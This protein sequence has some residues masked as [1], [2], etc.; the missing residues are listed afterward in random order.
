MSQNFRDIFLPQSPADNARAK[1]LSR[2]FGIF[3]EQIVS[4]WAD[5]ARSPYENLGRPTLKIDETDRGHTLDFT[6]RERASGR[7]YVSEMKCEIEYQNFKFFVL[8]HV[9]HL[10][11]HKKPAFEAFLRAAHP[12]DSQ[13]IYVGRRK[14]DSD[15][16]ILIWG[17]AS[18]EGRRGVIEAKGFHDVL[19]V[20]DICADL[21]AWECL[22]YAELIQ[23]RREWCNRLFDGLLT[24]PN[25]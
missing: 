8:E 23:Q 20:E 19:S 17:A 12:T 14:M 21:A 24:A 1:F 16:A 6:F 5:N 3:S 2:V 9:S 4:L 10:D 15:G 7:V 22:R 13:T 25:G 18:P 11:H